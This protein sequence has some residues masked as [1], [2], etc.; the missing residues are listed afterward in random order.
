M[1]DLELRFLGSGD[2]FGDGGR[3]QTCFCVRSGELR[4]LIDCG[5]TSLSAMKRFGV[6]P[7]SVDAILI[8]HFHADHYGGLPFFILD[9]QFSGRARPL[10]IA[11]PEGLRDRLQAATDALFPGASRTQQKFEIRFLEL[12]AGEPLSIGPLSVKGFRVAHSPES[13]PLGLRVEVGGKVIAYSGDTEW[14]EAL[15]PLAQGT[16]LF[17]CESYAFEK[18]IPYHLNYQT[19][20]RHRENLVTERLILTHFGPEALAHLSEIEFECAED[21]LAVGL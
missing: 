5:A 7:A 14:T 10:T 13:N 15:F 20:R 1:P 4:F 17:I 6:D 16:D 9:A 21:G 11:G 2:A 8:S 12:V 3:Y 18:Q 19:L